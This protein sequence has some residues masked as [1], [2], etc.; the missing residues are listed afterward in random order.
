MLLQ[1]PLPILLLLGL[2]HTR[3]LQIRSE[4]WCATRGYLHCIKE[5]K[6]QTNQQQK[7]KTSWRKFGILQTEVTCLPH[8]ATDGAGPCVRRK[9]PSY[10]LFNRQKN[11]M[12]FPQVEPVLLVTVIS[13]WSPWVYLVPRAFSSYFSSPVPLRAPASAHHWGVFCHKNLTKGTFYILE[14]LGFNVCVSDVLFNDRF[15]RWGWIFTPHKWKEPF[16]WS[17]KVQ[18]TKT[19]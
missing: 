7:S 19:G 13:M 4:G 5:L 3:D 15:W 9:D 17:S 12:S 16:I 18:R 6:Y 14:A 8:K 1:N 11:Q 2:F 10:S